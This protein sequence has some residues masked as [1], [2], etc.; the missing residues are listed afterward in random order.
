MVLDAAGELR[1]LDSVGY[2]LVKKFSLTPDEGMGDTLEPFLNIWWRVPLDES[3][4]QDIETSS[5][6]TVND[7]ETVRSALL[8]KNVIPKLIYTAGTQGTSIYTGTVDNKVFVDMLSEIAA[9]Q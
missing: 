7:L 6:E 1:V 5:E 2:F 9:S 8:K 3:S 4:M